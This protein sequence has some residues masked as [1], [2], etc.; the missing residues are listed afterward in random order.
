MRVK[1][2]HITPHTDAK[3]SRGRRVTADASARY[4]AA[5]ASRRYRTVAYRR[6]TASTA[7]PNNPTA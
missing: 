6:F 2:R 1:I 4:C 5:A 7:N 3:A